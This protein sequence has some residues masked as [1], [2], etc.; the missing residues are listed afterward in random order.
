MRVRGL[1]GLL[2]IC[3][4]TDSLLWGILFWGNMESVNAAVTV[5][6]EREFKRD[7]KARKGSGLPG[8]ILSTS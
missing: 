6:D 5:K 4:I 2:V 8:S 7:G 3:L 1:C